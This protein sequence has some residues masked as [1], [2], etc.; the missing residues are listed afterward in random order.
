[1]GLQDKAGKPKLCV[2]C[3]RSTKV[4]RLMRETRVS[5]PCSQSPCNVNLVN[6]TQRFVAVRHKLVIYV[7]FLFS[8]RM[9]YTLTYYCDNCDFTSSKCSYICNTFEF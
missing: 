9:P 6:R 7:I 2:K 8:K 5:Y 4:E 1:M 3:T